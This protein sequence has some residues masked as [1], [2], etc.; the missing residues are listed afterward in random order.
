MRGLLMTLVLLALADELPV[1]LLTGAKS[2]GHESMD[3]R[4]TV[5]TIFYDALQMV[6]KGSCVIH[7]VSSSPRCVRLF[8]KG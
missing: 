6:E 3:T 4:V 5:Q 8:D 1:G 2:Y 7:F